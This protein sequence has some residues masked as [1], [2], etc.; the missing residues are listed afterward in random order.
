[1]VTPYTNT[2]KLN[3]FINCFFA[4]VGDIDLDDE[5]LT[6]QYKKPTFC[7]VINFAHFS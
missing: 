4:S 3:K 1:M 2:S 7:I 6:K 5:I